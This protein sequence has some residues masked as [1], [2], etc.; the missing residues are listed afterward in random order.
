MW[1]YLPRHGVA[2]EIQYVKESS[3]KDDK[4]IAN[5]FSEGYILKV[6]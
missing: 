2:P 6:R 1:E 4:K 5:R 3:K